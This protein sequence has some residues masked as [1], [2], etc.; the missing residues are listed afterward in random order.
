MS[1]ERRVPKWEEYPHT[2][3]VFVRAA[4]KRLAG[5][6]TW[7]SVRKMEGG[8]ECTSMWG[9]VRDCPHSLIFIS[10][11]RGLKEIE[12]REKGRTDLVEESGSLRGDW[13]GA[14]EP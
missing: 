9:V 3:G 8:A 12:R 13:D 7:K 1:G 11:G 10:A 6:G 2:P 5:Y 14:V 4:N